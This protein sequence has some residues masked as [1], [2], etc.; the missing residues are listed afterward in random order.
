MKYTIAKLHSGLDMDYAVK[1][2]GI[3]IAEFW[4]RDHAIIF[5]KTME[6]KFTPNNSDYTKYKRALED[7]CEEMIDPD[8][9]PDTVAD[10]VFKI[11]YTA[12]NGKYE[13]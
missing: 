10:K 1:Q 3:R 9:I 12:I 8:R 13:K 6:A 5:K 4:H 11:A 7:I 2:N